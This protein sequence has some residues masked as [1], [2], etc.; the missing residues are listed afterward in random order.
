MTWPLQRI[1]SDP[2]RCTSFDLRAQQ[3]P[4]RMR[5]KFF[6]TMQK[7]AVVPDHQVTDPPPVAPDELRLG[8]MQPK[9]LKQD[10]GLVPR[11]FIDA[12]VEEGTEKERVAAGI[13]MGTNERM[14]GSGPR[15]RTVQTLSLIH[16]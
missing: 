14:N 12:G 1:R 6:A 4:P 16:I 8:G 10:I 11:Q 3:N 2:G 13:R 5:G 9:E 7:A 15:L